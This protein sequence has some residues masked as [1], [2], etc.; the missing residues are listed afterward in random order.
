MLSNAKRKFYKDKVS[1]LRNVNPKSWYRQLKSIT[2]MG[3]SN[4]TPEVEDIKDHTDEEQ[5]EMI[6]ESFAKISKEYEPLDRSAIKLPAI[7]KEDV[8][9]VSEAEVLEVLKSM[10]TSKAVPRNDV[11]TK[12]FKAFAEQLCAPIT[13][14]INE[15]IL[16]GYWPE[17]LKIETVTPVPKVSHPQTLDDIRKICGLLNLSKILEKVICKYL[18]ADMKDALDKSQYANQKG[19]SINHYLVKLVDRVLNALDG[20]TKGENTAVIA[21]YLDWSKAFDR[22]DPTL[23]IQ[24]FQAN[25]VRPSLIPLLMSFFEGRTMRVR[26]HNVMS[27]SKKLP[28]GGPQGTSL[29]I[30]SYLSQTNDNPEGASEKDIFKFVD[31]KSLLEVVD[32]SNVGIASHNFKER[33]PSNVPISNCVIPKDNLRTQKY[34]SD[35]D[36]WTNQKKMKL[37]SKKTKNQ[38][39]NFSKKHQFSTDIKIMNDTIETISEVKLLG[40]TI[41]SDLSWSRNT[42]NLV[43]DSN[44]RMQFLHRAKKFTNNI[45]DL[46]KIYMLQIRSKLEQSAAVWHSSLTKKDSRDL[47][48]VQ[49][50]ALKVILGEKYQNY[51]DALRTI[52]IDSLEERRQKICLK[53][54]QQ[55]LRNE[56]LRDMF[57]KNLSDH[58]MKKRSVEKFIVTKASTER[59]RKSAIPSMQRQLNTDDKKK[60]EIFKIIENTVPVNNDYYL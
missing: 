27:S 15:A 51:E 34:V 18:V 40:T 32:L 6:A 21:T 8:L 16:T 37:N 13:M 48:R 39:F 46:K 55:C 45:K 28:G 54:A 22:Q 57:P 47:E 25:G 5:A 60:R 19:L 11:S 35:I 42:E 29:G 59:L 56:K 7:K 10:D 14:L 58:K 52:K 49:K 2:K 4:D 44:K 1:K 50:A 41:T 9:Q 24:S 3:K 43:K 53:F 38:I 31:D 17:F 20:S 33:I 26:W 12:I 30:W 23:A 36:I